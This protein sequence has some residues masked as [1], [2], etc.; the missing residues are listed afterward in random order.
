ME[1]PCS[2]IWRSAGLTHIGLVRQSNQDAFAVLN[3]YGLWIVADGMGGRAGGKVASRLAV[4]TIASSCDSFGRFPQ[5][6][7]DNPSQ[8]HPST[9]LREAI[10]AANQAIR[11]EAITQPALAGMGTTVV[12][13]HLRAVPS[14]SP[15]SN[16]DSA[17]LPQ[18]T[19]ATTAHLGDSRAYL[20]RDRSLTRL[21]RD[22]SWVEDRIRQGLLSPEEALTHPLRHMLTNALG[23]EASATPTLSAHLLQPGDRLLLCTDGLTKMLDDA[24]IA[25]A[26]LHA[27][28][29][30]QAA[31]QTL[32]ERANQRGGEDN[33]TVVVVCCKAVR[34]RK[35][36]TPGG[37]N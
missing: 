22:H 25:D 13:L 18:T 24:Q 33:T 10:R 1:Q 29:M 14:S 15:S 16:P 23:T 2:Q 5:H 30:P 32:I 7:P 20:L 12:V 37:D 11:A 31:C 26:L 35:T 28:H 3:E 17:P 34:D 27:G 21:T 9:A 4:E 36:R 8:K 19:Q 6:H